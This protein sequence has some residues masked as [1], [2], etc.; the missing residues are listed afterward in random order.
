MIKT[1][2][3]YVGKYKKNAILGPL[4]L[5]G[6]VFMDIVQP[7]VVASLIATAARTQ[8]HRAVASWPETNTA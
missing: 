6:E 3:K 8:I 5:L 2:A 7:F 1:L 4:L